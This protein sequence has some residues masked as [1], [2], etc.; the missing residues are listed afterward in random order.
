MRIVNK[1]CI[2]EMDEWFLLYPVFYEIFP[3]LF[4]L[5]YYKILNTW[6]CLPS[7]CTWPCSGS[8][9]SGHSFSGLIHDNPHNPSHRQSFL[10][11][12]QSLSAEHLLT[13]SIPAAFTSNSLRM[14][15]FF[16]WGILRDTLLAGGGCC[17]LLMYLV[18]PNTWV[19][20]MGRGI[21]SC[22]WILKCLWWEALIVAT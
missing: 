7:S 4:Y 18:S 11:L 15:Q 21:T 13:Q 1:C 8:G 20:V 10:S 12:V 22:S 14:G 19:M 6:K 5:S 3:P 16:S 2:F 9:S 17:C